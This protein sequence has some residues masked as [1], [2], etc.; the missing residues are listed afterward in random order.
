M[1][2]LITYSVLRWA[3]ESRVYAEDPLR[4]FLPSIGIAVNLFKHFILM[5]FIC[6]SLGPLNTYREPEKFVQDGNTIRIDTGVYEGGVISMYYDPMISKLCS[7]ASDRYCTTLYCT[8][9]I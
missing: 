2:V 4:N 3:I 8:A 6:L 5:Y 1:M 7:H 9:H